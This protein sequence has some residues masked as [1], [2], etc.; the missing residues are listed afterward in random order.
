MSNLAKHLCCVPL[1]LTC[2]LF[3]AT[4]CHG[5]N[6]PEPR[7]K[8]VEGPM[9][10]LAAV[11]GTWEIDTAWANGSSLWARNE[12]KV[13]L[14]GK[15]IEAKTYA[16]NRSGVAYQRYHT[17]F[18]YDESTKEYKSWGFTYDGTEKTVP[19]KVE[20]KDGKVTLTSEWSQDESSRIRQSVT[21]V[22]GDDHYEWKV[23]QQSG[24]ED[25]VEIMNG[26]WQRV[27]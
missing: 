25:W 23:W 27:D 8:L 12:Y 2:L 21:I 3:S 7:A 13:G 4:T 15:F 9:T 16:K 1:V 20:E 18:G 11:L 26:Q 6:M 24:S 14:G 22:D 5:Q 10:R 17:V 19:I